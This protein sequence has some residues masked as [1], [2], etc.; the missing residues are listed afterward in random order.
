MLKIEISLKCWS[1]TKL[2]P[3]NPFLKNDAFELEKPAAFL[4]PQETHCIRWDEHKNVT[5]SSNKYTRGRCLTVKR[6]ALSPGAWSWLPSTHIRQLTSDCNFSC[7]ASDALLWLPQALHL[8]AQTPKHR[9]SYILIHFKERNTT[10]KI[11]TGQEGTTL[12]Y[13]TDNMMLYD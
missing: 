6:F 12:S 4:N 9:S 11:N 5:F 7:R 3:Q 1:L 2:W 8:C 13:L 10:E